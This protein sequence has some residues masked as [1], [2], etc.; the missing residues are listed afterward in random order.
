M[1]CGTAAGHRSAEIGAYYAHESNKFWRILEQVDLTPRQLKPSEFQLLPEFGIGLTDLAK[2]YKGADS[3][4]V[5]GDIDVAGFRSKVKSVSPSVLAFNGKTAAKLA[6]GHRTLHA[7]RQVGR[8]GDT[9]VFVLPSTSGRAGGY[10]DPAP[11]R[12]CA[13][14]VRELRD[15]GCV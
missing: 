5:D 14:F 6:L 12:E 8:L 15:R 4:L 11:W 1:I 7:G 13:D 10:W 9:V 3:G 2:Y